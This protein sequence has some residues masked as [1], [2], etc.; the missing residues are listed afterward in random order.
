M[1]RKRPYWTYVKSIIKEYPALKRE[2]DTPRIP[3]ITAT[4]NGVGHGSGVSDPTAD[5]VVH[6][7]PREKMRK[8]EA[9]EQAIMETKRVYDNWKLR[10]DVVDYVY[11]RRAYTIEG[12]AMRLYIHPNSAGKYQA[13]FI[14]LVAHYLDLPEAL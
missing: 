7:L 6:D 5:A 2:R 12:A 4:Y 8:L 3:K 14:K 13:D 9:V 10:L 11:W 1:S